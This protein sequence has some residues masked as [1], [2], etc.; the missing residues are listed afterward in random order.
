MNES[1]L[2][3][4]NPRGAAFRHLAGGSLPGVPALGAGALPPM[5]GGLSSL[6]HTWRQGNATLSQ[7]WDGEGELNH[8]HPVLGAECR[9][10]MVSARRPQQECR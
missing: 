2:D 6:P 10:Q 5:E 3:L 9:S 4:P 1:N 7:V 8:H